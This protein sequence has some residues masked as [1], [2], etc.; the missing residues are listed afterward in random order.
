M[1]RLL[2]LSYLALYSC[3][4]TDEV[5]APIIGESIT[6]QQDQL[7]LLVG[8]SAQVGAL[9]FN[10]YGTQEDL[11][12]L[13]ESENENIATVDIDGTVVALSPGQSSLTANVGATKSDIL[14]VT[15]VEDVTA[16]AQVTI[17]SPMGLQIEVG[18]E[19]QIDVSVFNVIDEELTGLDVSFESLD[20]DHIS[21]D[22]TGKVTGLA[23]GTGRIVANVQGIE[24]NTIEFQIGST[25][26]P[27]TFQ[28]ANGYNSS[29]TAELFIDE[30]G[31]LILE[32]KD[33]FE[34]EFA[35]GTYIYLSNSTSGFVTRNQGLDLGEITSGGFHSFNVSAI[36]S[37]VTIDDFQYV[38][39]LCKPAA[40]TFG[41][42]QLN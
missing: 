32:L 10:K 25:S 5:E 14:Q 30:N 37:N 23:N 2:I 24:S 8:D 35:L 31:D 1:K 36:D 6:L 9:F 22:Q 38:I 34:A 29:G 40:I 20:S 4:G 18:Q 41:Y 39:V 42:A 3:I 13:W 11:Q 19:V 27:G 15:V 28:D 16:V 26:R 12:V 33:D 21:V 7:A 17:S